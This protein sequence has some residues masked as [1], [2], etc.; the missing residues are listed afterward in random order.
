M[1]GKECIPVFFLVF[2]RAVKCL[3]AAADI[4]SW[5]TTNLAPKHH[6]LAN[7]VHVLLSLFVLFIFSD[8]LHKGQTKRKKKLRKKEN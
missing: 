4:E 3:F 8:D 2:F 5:T 7:G 6:V 1:A